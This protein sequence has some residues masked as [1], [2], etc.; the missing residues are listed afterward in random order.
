MLLASCDVCFAVFGHLTV[1]SVLHTDV[2]A[3]VSRMYTAD[4]HWPKL[5]AALCPHITALCGGMNVRVIGARMCCSTYIIY[6]IRLAYSVARLFDVL[7]GSEDACIPCSV[8]VVIGHKQVRCFV[9]GNVDKADCVSAACGVGNNAQPQCT[10]RHT[11][12]VGVCSAEAA[13]LLV[14]RGFTVKALPRLVV[15]W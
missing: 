7:L 14:V 8:L 13:C 15:P 11:L 2:P 4:G 3:K 5:T 1:R 10:F 6:C 9:I 12:S